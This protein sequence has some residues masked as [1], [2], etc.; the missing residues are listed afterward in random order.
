MRQSE[1]LVKYVSH[2]GTPV[3]VQLSMR[4]SHV[5]CSNCWNVNV[6]INE[7]YEADMFDTYT[8]HS[9]ILCYF[10]KV[11]F[12]TFEF[13]GHKSWQTS[14]GT[15]LFLSFL[16]LSLVSLLFFFFIFLSIFSFISFFLCLLFFFFVY[17]TSLFSFSLSL[18]HYL[19]LFLI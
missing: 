11:R 17:F 1:S 18:L 7:C 14:P 13:P 4:H 8:T 3:K 5:T 6:Y 15:F 2:L 16:F 19:K 12:P 10:G 9:N